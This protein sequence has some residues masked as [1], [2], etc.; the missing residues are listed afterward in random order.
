MNEENL[1]SVDP[2]VVAKLHGRLLARFPRVVPPPHE[3]LAK[4]LRVAANASLLQEEGR[5]TTFA[6][7]LTSNLT[8]TDA[9]FLSLGTHLQYDAETIRGLAPVLG[10]AFDFLVVVGESNPSK[11][12]IAGVRNASTSLRQRVSK[13]TEAKCCLTAAKEARLRVL[14]VC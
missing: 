10:T 11:L 9:G 2:A 3:Q 1:W 14:R 13:F 12:K 7:L 6:L 4:L 8:P 5:P